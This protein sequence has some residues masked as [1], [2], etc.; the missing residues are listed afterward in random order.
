MRFLA[1]DLGAT[2]IKS[3]VLDLD[4]LRLLRVQ[5]APF[6]PFL[7]GGNR[8]AREVDPEVILAVVRREVES[9]LALEPTIEGIVLCGQMHGL[10]LTDP[11]GKALSNVVSW[12]DQRSLLPSESSSSGST[13]FD[14]L[15]SALTDEERVELG[16]EL[17]PGLPIATLFWMRESG[18]LPSGDVV[19]ASLSDFVAARLCDSPVV[20]DRTNAAAYGS[21]FVEAGRWHEAV[22]EKLGL[23]KLRW[24]KILGAQA[25]VG[26]LSH[27]SRRI[28]FFVPL[29]DQQAGL[30]GS[31]LERSELSV[32]VATGSQVAS[33]IPVYQSGPWQVRPYFD[34][35]YI[36]TVTHI[37][38]GRAL[39]VLVKLIS[40]LATS[41]EGD[42]DPWGYALDR[43]EGTPRTDLRVDLSF[44]S[45]MTGSAGAI[46]NIQ[47]D[48]LTVGHLL[49][50][51]VTAMAESYARYAGQL[52]G[53]GQWR[54][55][56]FSGGLARKSRSLREAISAAVALPYRMAGSNE[57][58]L[59][60]LLCHALVVSGRKS[61]ASEAARDLKRADERGH[62]WS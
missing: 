36:K 29:G 34:D 52:G 6:P 26:Y 2:F 32:N 53:E 20:T 45:S 55:I 12:Q 62:R 4:A 19:P 60:G 27:R 42:I 15:A 39:N 9:L 41:A 8:R 7:E 57:E 23:E 10:V 5:R 18:S 13:Y 51:A 37:P 43:L 48:N 61:S 31:F 28:P 25:R 59:Q 3:A 30:L 17:R 46:T 38:A 21:F 22:I 54:T 1:V 24:P 47:E 56:A 33:I 35:M 49:R 11:G 14:V 58:T 16:N 44:F 50:G 40:E